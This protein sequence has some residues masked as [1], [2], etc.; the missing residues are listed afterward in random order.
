V[1][2]VVKVV[3]V[4]K[5]GN[6]IT[7]IKAIKK[8]DV[9]KDRSEQSQWKVKVKREYR[10]REQRRWDVIETSFALAE[11]RTTSQPY[12]SSRSCG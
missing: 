1:A 11:R 3:K 6:V 5:M 9:M 4:V 7:V 12:S 8:D 2:K 10:K